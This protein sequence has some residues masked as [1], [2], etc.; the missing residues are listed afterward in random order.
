MKNSIHDS[1]TVVYIGKNLTKD[2]NAIVARSS[3]G[4][5][6]F[7]YLS[8]Q[9]FPHNAFKNKI[10]KGYHGFSYQMPNYSYRYIA[11][12]HSPCTNVGYNWHISSINENG[13]AVSATL[14]CHT[15][16]TALSFDPFVKT[17]IGE[18]N[19]VQIA[20]SLATSSYEAME[21]IARIVDKQGND[22]PTAIFAVD[23][24]EVWYMEIYT[25]HQYIAFKLPDDKAFIIG[26]EF[27]LANISEFKEG[28]YFTS[29]DL[30][31]LPKKHGFA[32]YIGGNDDKHMHLT[33]TYGDV[34]TNDFEC[35]NVH[36]RT[37]L[38]H[39][40]F[41]PNSSDAKK[42]I[43]TKRYVPYITPERNDYTIHDVLKIMRNRFDDIID[44]ENFKEFKRDLSLHLLRLVGSESANQVHAITVH[45]DFNKEIA[46]EEWI[47]I[48]N[49]NYSP[50][51]PFNN[52]LKALHP[53]YSYIP[54]IYDYDEK[55]AML[56]YKRLNVLAN[57]NRKCY[58]S[59]IQALWEDY[60]HIW[61]HEYHEILKCAKTLPLEKVKDIISK[62]SLRI[63]EEALDIARYS[64]NDLLVHVMNSENVYRP[65]DEE[66]RIKVFHPLVPLKTYTARFGLHYHKKNS[67]TIVL[68]KNNNTYEITL[69]PGI[70]G[71]TGILK[72]KDK[73]LNVVTKVRNHIVYI[74]KDDI[75][76]IITNKDDIETPIELINL[77]PSKK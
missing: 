71:K 44:D 10:V 36:R 53:T 22:E 8:A 14:T 49:A 3:D 54:P 23:Q 66:H 28:D 40:L 24:K 72:Y 46:C 58:A 9:I 42:Y 32:K 19:F 34:L 50:F 2:G 61:D 27:L 26:N 65:N 41:A 67:K 13:V 6:L 59:R 18:D 48:S 5:P 76:A 29:K 37:W 64:F 73:S 63:Q 35:D 20:G 39:H 21:I 75:D 60:E 77:K 1:C 70:A 11:T 15:N 33:E 31:N 57:Y 30:F 62:Y 43:S 69:A 51:L 7:T 16:K 17:G 68:T 47:A 12:P 45:K 52:G 74:A 55:S 56:I 4:S 38:T 25:G